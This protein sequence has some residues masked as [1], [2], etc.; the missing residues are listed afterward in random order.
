MSGDGWNIR[1]WFVPL[2]FT[3]DLQVPAKL[4]GENTRKPGLWDVSLKS[5]DPKSTAVSWAGFY[6]LQLNS[7]GMQC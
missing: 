6:R 2:D 7:S 5:R 3:S 1:V 4:R